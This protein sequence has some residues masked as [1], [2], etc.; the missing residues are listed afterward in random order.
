M[1]TIAVLEIVGLTCSLSGLGLVMQRR[2]RL[3]REVRLCL[4]TLLAVVAALHLLDTLEWLGFAWADWLGDTFKVVVPVAW[5]AF[6]FAVTRIELASDLHLAA[7]QLGNLIEAAPAALAVVDAEGRCLHCNQRWLDLH[8]IKTSIVGL[9]LSA[10][11]GTLGTM[12]ETLS[13]QVV[14]T[15]TP[16]HGKD[17]VA[18]AGEANAPEV[19]WSVR[20]WSSAEGKGVI[21]AVV[22]IQTSET[23]ASDSIRAA[24]RSRT[25][26][27]IGAAASGVAHDIN[28]LLTVISMHS[29]VLHLLKGQDPEAM[30]SSLDS[31][32]E[33]IGTA[34]S[35]TR[36]LLSFSKLQAMELEPLD[37]AA[38]VTSNARLLEDAVRGKAEL[39][40]QA[41]PQVWVSA[42]ASA[43][44]QILLNLVVNGRD[45]LNH[46]GAITIRVET[47]VNGPSLAVQDSGTGIEPDVLAHMFE[48]FFTTKRE[49]GTGLGLAV[50]DRLVRAQGGSIDVRSSIGEGTTFVITFPPSTPTA[51]LE[52]RPRPPIDFV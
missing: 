17:K 38:L 50:V 29:E 27:V 42:N 18:L 1:N 32:Q 6:L 23:K 12:W 52:S 34:S 48:P 40:L 8:R 7:A 20:P 2:I 35:M 22:P 11:P 16:L 39:S 46:F 30:K 45:A 43:L 41:Q 3:P 31:I 10:T 21:V 26:E 36:E 33:A 47:T 25:L 19:E 37:L 4:T 28:N 5:L 9:P 49:R 13:R 15:G 24:A 14:L 44:Q 51:G